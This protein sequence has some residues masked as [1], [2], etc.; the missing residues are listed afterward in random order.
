MLVERSADFTPEL[1]RSVLDVVTRVYSRVFDVDGALATLRVLATE[2]SSLLDPEDEAGA[3]DFAQVLPATQTLEIYRRGIDAAPVIQ[4][5]FLA[6]EIGHNIQFSLDFDRQRQEEISRRNYFA[7]PHFFELVAPFG[8][9]IVET[10]SRKRS[11]YRL[12]RPQY[13]SQE[14]Y[15]YRYL[16]EPVEDWAEWLSAIFEEVGEKRYLEDERLTELH[17]VGDYSLS[18]PW[19]WYSDQIIAYLYIA[20]LDSLEESC[21]PAEW[22]ALRQSF[23]KEIVEAEWPYFRFENGRGAAIQDHFREAYPLA[24]EDVTYL[25]RSYLL[26]LYP[27]LCPLAN[28]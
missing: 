9:S 17:I 20:I 11:D 6:H 24:V 23:Q 5:G 10:R 2:E 22:N 25:A 19:E 8:W 3:S 18:G 4:L 26:P 15:V 12:F 27:R 1:A 21:P 28:P 14:P 13:I 7:A 16:E